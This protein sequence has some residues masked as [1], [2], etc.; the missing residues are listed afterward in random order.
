MSD[1]PE[2]ESCVRCDTVRL[3]FNISFLSW[4]VVMCFDDGYPLSFLCMGWEL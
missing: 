4:A 3:D 1:E 2:F